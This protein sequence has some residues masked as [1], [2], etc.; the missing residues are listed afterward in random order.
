MRDIRRFGGRRAV[1]PQSPT[2]S[3]IE[4]ADVGALLDCDLGSTGELHLQALA[5][6][7][8]RAAAFRCNQVIDHLNAEMR[9]FVGRMEMAWIASSD[10]SGAADCS[11]RAGP[12][13]FVRVLDRRTL[14]YPEYRGNGV[15]ASLA[16]I[17]EQPH[18]SLLFLDFFRTRV[19]LH[20]NGWAEVLGNDEM[21]GHPR[22][23]AEIEAD[24][25]IT[26]GRHPQCWVLVTVVEAYIHCSKHVPLLV[27]APTEIDW[28]TDD[29]AKKG[30]D[31]FGVAQQRRAA[32]DGH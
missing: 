27:K 25:A 14:A 31:A 2:A 32:R 8:T 22:R 19:G 30:G 10:L 17:E 24:L 23:T 7:A 20:V 4:N 3:V 15:L 6:T 26:G 9:A 18:A 12:A 5:G 1:P 21:A 16:N 11:F 29:P 28:G 13:G